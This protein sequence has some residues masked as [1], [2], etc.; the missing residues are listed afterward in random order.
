M[1]I[2]HFHQHLEN[3]R[4]NPWGQGWYFENF[5]Y[6]WYL[7]NGGHFWFFHNCWLWYSVFIDTQK[8]G[9]PNFGEGSVIWN[10]SIWLIFK[11]W[12]PFFDLFIMTDTDILFP[13]T[14]RKLKTQTFGVGSVIFNT[15][16]IYEMVAFFDFFIMADSDILLLLT[17]GKLETHTLGGQ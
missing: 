7:W 9:N 4:P 3:W 1:L 2:F 10:F 14:L 13:L 16:D 8:P 17:L 5:L 6:D 11:K 15:I 12:Q